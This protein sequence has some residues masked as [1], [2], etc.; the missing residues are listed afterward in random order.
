MEKIIYAVN[1]TDP[2]TGVRFTADIIWEEKGYTTERYIAD[3][4]KNGD[5]DWCE[6]LR[7]G[8]A[9]VYAVE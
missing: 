4:E 9:E 2:E 6:T 8:D 5:T 3:C 1:V 7:K